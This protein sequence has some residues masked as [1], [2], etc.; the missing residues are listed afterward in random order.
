MPSPLDTGATIDRVC[1]NIS[2]ASNYFA[3]HVAFDH[4]CDA[5][6]VDGDDH[7]DRLLETIRV[8]MPRLAALCLCRAWDSPKQDL[9]TIW[10]LRS[11]QDLSAVLQATDPEFWRSCKKFKKCSE[12]TKMKSFRNSDLA[13]NKP[14][15]KESNVHGFSCSDLEVLVRQA[16]SIGDRLIKAAQITN[17]HLG[18][19]TN[20]HLE[21]E[22]DDKV[23]A[24]RRA[25]RRISAAEPLHQP[26]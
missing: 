25:R 11:D 17:L 1:H 8:G 19:V 22:L 9:V 24:F 20:L 2:A 13:H 7:A 5:D 16:A 6:V 21:Y 4:S 18:R 15:A 23:E 14:L 10:S 26:A 3:A 12:F